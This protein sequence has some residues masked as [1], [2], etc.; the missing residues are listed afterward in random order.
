MEV[1]VG[2]IRKVYGILSVQLI[3]TVAIAAPICHLGKHWV[4]SNQWMLGIS[5]VCLIATMCA[6]CCCQQELRTFPINYVFLLVITAGMSVLVGFSSAMYSPQSVLLAAGITTFIFLAMTAYAVFSKTDFTGFGPYL[7]GALFC[8]MGF[9]LAISLMS[10][11]LGPDKI[12]MALMLCNFMG[13]LLFT[14]YI[15]YDTQL[16]MGEL[17]GH[18][19]QFGIDDYVFAALNLYLDIINL[20]LHLLQL[21]GDRR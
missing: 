13:V 11:F 3:M 15:V 5:M 4:M 12:N 14:F 18:Q 17:G 21:F 6:M 16:I 19:Q 10:F 1:R 2:F 8:L 20:F 7:M 9:G